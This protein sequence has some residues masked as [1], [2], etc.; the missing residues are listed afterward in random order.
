MSHE[1]AEIIRF[2]SGAA[3]ALVGSYEVNGIISDV[4]KKL[5][6]EQ[7]I[8]AYGF[9][10]AWGMHLEIYPKSRRRSVFMGCIVAMPVWVIANAWLSNF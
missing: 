9:G 1:T 4:N 6:A 3:L 8:G 7:A 5:P 10:R 2:A